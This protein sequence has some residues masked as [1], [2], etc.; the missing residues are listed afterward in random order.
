M[1]S[2]GVSPKPIAIQVEELISHVQK[3]QRMTLAM[4]KMCHD[5]EHSIMHLL[6]TLHRGMG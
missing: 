6:L 2:W 4:V 5:I 3:S 1:S